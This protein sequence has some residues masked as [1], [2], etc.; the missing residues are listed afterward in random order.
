[1]KDKHALLGACCHLAPV[2]VRKPCREALKERTRERVP[3][4][5]A[6]TQ[7]NLGA[8]LQA[9]GERE[10]STKKLEAA[11]SAFELALR[12]AQSSGATYYTEIFQRNLNQCRDSLNKQK[13]IKEIMKR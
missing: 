2:A 5:W 10:N 8:A 11:Q 6:R 1:M 9:L 3:L 12:V 7:N 4:D 13:S